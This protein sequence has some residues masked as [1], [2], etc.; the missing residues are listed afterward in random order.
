VAS[1]F[2]VAWHHDRAD[3]P[4]FMWHELDDDRNETRKVEEF[5]DGVRLRADAAHPDGET[6][7]SYEPMPSLDFIEA[8]PEFTV[9]ACTSEEFEQ[10][11]VTARY[12]R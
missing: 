10:V 8:Q 5:R 4:T 7:L 1:Y 2:A 11:W 9:H 6:A 3:E 12:A